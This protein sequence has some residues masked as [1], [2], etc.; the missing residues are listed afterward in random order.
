M[1]ASG[2][3]WVGLIAFLAWP[4][5]GQVPSIPLDEL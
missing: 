1:R 4:A 5:I 3:L 2:M